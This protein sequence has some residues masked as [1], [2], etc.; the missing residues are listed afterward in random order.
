M[1]KTPSSS[2]AL[3]GALL[4]GPCS[5]DQGINRVVRMRSLTMSTGAAP[6]CLGRACA[7]GFIARPPTNGD[8]LAGNYLA[9]PV[10]REAHIA[11]RPLAA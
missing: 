1:Q 10:T 9:V 6:L 4:P 11:A 5:G 7:S 2:L 3:T 8:R